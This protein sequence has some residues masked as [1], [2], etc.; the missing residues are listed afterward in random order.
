[1]REPKKYA[2]N[3]RQMF[4]SS[5][6]AY[7]AYDR[8]IKFAYYNINTKNYKVVIWIPGVM[9]QHGKLI[10]IGL[11]DENAYSSTRGFTKATTYASLSI[12]GLSTIVILTG[13]PLIILFVGLLISG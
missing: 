11:I 13:V 4:I 7:G 12:T 6:A 8:Y 9:N 10:N 5:R 3:K 1:M 2:I